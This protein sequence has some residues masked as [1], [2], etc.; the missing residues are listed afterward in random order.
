MWSGAAAGGA[1][2]AGAPKGGRSR[3]SSAS[4]TST[5]GPIAV[6]VKQGGTVKWVWAA[7]NTD[8]HDVHLKQGPK[9][10]EAKAHYSTKTTAV[11]NARFTRSLRNSGHLSLHLHDPPDA[12][13]ADGDGAEGREEPVTGRRAALLSP[14]VAV[15]ISLALAPS[16]LAANT[17]VSISNYAWAPAQVHIDLDEKVTWDWLGPDLAHSVTGTSAN[18]RQWDS[19]PNTDAPYHSA[20]ILLHDPVHA[21]G[22]L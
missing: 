21:A 17:R 18:A 19:D 9:G 12:D 6:T 2:T 8:P 15:A 22:R 14:F 13:E 7:T 1:V 4:P 20:G 10:L 5:S 3:S 11:T 16:A